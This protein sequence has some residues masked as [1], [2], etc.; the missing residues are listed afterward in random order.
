MAP[1]DGR[2]PGVD[3]E[4]GFPTRLAIAMATAGVA[5]FLLWQLSWV[6]LLVFGALIVAAAIDGASDLL[7]KFTPL[8]DGPARIAAVL[9]LTL[10]IAAFLFLLGQQVSEQFAQLID[11]M[12]DLIAGAGEVLG[13]EDMGAAVSDVLAG[14]VD[15]GAFAGGIGAGLVGVIG[16]ASAVVLILIGGVYFAFEAGL[17]QRGLLSLV[18]PRYR[19]SIAEALAAAS[20][21]L[22]RWL[23]G[24]AVAMIVVGSAVAILMMAVGLPS[25]LAIGV[26]AGILEFIPFLGPILAAVPALL[27]ALGEGEETFFWVAAGYIL[28]QQI[29]GNVLVPLIQKRA[30]HLPPALGLFSIVGF[31]ILLGPWGVILATPLTIVIMVLVQKLYLPR[32][33]AIL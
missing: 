11:M 16:T 7:A 1:D 30:V 8:T 21:A 12:P 3:D 14:S 6:L 32:N 2:R 13:I 28:I 18:P 10:G 29:E 15:L 24:Q 17:Y 19:D 33:R 4:P 5:V 22:K 9:I 31:G 26:I 20:D 25:A 23:A 27:V